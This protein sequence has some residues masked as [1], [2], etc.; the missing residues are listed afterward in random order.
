[1]KRF[2]AM[3][4][5]ALMLTGACAMAAE[6]PIDLFVAESGTKVT[7][8]M[9]NPFNIEFNVVD[10]GHMQAFISREGVEDIVVIVDKTDSDI[11]FNMADM[12][13]EDKQKQM[14]YIKNVEFEGYTEVTVNIEKTPAGNEYFDV[15]ASYENIN[16]HRRVTIFEGYYF[17][18]YQMSTTAFTDADNA[19]MDEVQQGMWIK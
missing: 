6:E 9:Q 4:L 15:F 19:F 2:L 8:T 11:D 14:E 13:D 12:S 3:L 18:R 16:V 5:A 1:M 17:D 7:L 10:D